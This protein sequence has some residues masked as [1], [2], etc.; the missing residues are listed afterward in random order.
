[1]QKINKD[2]E[3]GDTIKKYRK[4][5]QWIFSVFFIYA[6]MVSISLLNFSALSSEEIKGNYEKSNQE[7]NLRLRNIAAFQSNDIEILDSIKH[8]KFIDIITSDQVKERIDYPKYKAYLDRISG[9]KDNKLIQE[10]NEQAEKEAVQNILLIGIDSRR[11]D[12]QYGRA[13]TIMIASLNK[14]KETIKLIS[15]MRDT[16]VK[17]SGYRNNKINATYN[18]GG[19]KLLKKTLN[20]NFQLNLEKYVVVDFSGFEKVIDAIGGL[21][22]NIKKYEVN[23]LNRCI[24]DLKRRK[25]KYIKKSGENHLNG[26][27]VL[28]YSRIRNVGDSDY[29]RTERQRT[30]IKRMIEKI[31]DLPLS[32]YPGILTSIYPYV[33]TNLTIKECLALAKDYYDVE[34]WNISGMRIPTKESGRP[35]KINAMW[36]IDPN[37]KECTRIMKEFAGL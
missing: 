19:A 12:F 26:M 16:Y 18:F 27:Q 21:D 24:T 7:E 34:N 23:E 14:S 33:K 2:R 11:R 20:S 4:M 25:V 6:L 5:F 10:Q 3:R 15:V 8:N 32:K 22:V 1:M 31:K 29:E 17:I 30:V 28:A 37:I 36:V 13:D 9:S 35:K